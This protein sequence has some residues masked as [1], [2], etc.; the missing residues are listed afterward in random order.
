MVTL[1][2]IDD[3]GRLAAA[4]AADTLVDPIGRSRG[5]DARRSASMPY[6]QRIAVRSIH[7]IV[8]VPIDDIVRLEAED[9]YV[10]IWADR[11]WLHKETLTR[12]CARLDPAL[13]L[14][15][16][17]SHA[18]SL[19]ML[20]ELQPCPHGEFRLVLT[21]GTELRSGRSYRTQIETALGLT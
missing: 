8:I 6:A 9:N 4:P 14:R 20:R 5:G 19:R 1:G 17:R 2:W 12:L 16:H 13:F 15:I 11:A 18:V 7:R 3:A 21:D 10:R